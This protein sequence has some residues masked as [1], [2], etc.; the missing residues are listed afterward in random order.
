MFTL[1]IED[2]PDEGLNLHWQEEP[3]TLSGYLKNLSHID[4]SFEGPLQSEASLRKAGQIVLIKGHI[5]TL[6]RLQC[7]RCL[8]NFLYPIEASFDLTLHPLKG[9]HF[10]E[11]V[12]LSREEMELDFFEGGEIH[13]SEI[14][15]EQVFLEIPIKPLCEENCKGLCPVCGK[16]LNISSCDCLREEWGSAF[17]ALQKLKLNH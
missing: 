12:E 4:F 17:S 15:C 8:T 16:N 13:L 6:L 10:S 7:V 11:E 5:Q 2:I 9:I 1:N 14:A 3:I